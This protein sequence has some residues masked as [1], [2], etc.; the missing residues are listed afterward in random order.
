MAIFGL[1]GKEKSGKMTLAITRIVEIRED[2]RNKKHSRPIQVAN[3]FRDLCLD[4]HVDPFN[5]AYDG[6]GG[7]VVFGALLSELWSPKLLSVQFGGAPSDLRSSMADQRTGKQSY[8]NRVT[9]LWFQGLEFVQSEQIRGLPG[10]VAKELQARRYET[11]KQGEFLKTKVETKAEMKVRTGGKS[12]DCFVAGTLIST[13]SGD[14]PIESLFVGQEVLTP[15]G[16]SKIFAIHESETDS[17]TRVG[18]SNGKHLSGKGAHK[19]FT[20]D[21]GWRRMDTL[22]LTNEIESVKNLPIWKFLNALSTKVKTTGFKALADI[23]LADRK[24]HRRR[25]FYTDLSGLSTTALFLK[26][27]SFIIKTLIG[28]TTTLP[29]LNLWKAASIL[30]CTCVNALRTRLS[31]SG[32]VNFWTRLLPL[33]CIGTNHQ[34]V[35]RGISEMERCLG[36][37]VNELN[38][39]AGA[40]KYSRLS[41]QQ[42]IALSVVSTN[43]KE[44]NTGK[45]EGALF[46]AIHLMFSNITQRRIALSSVEQLRLPAERP[47]KVFNL[48]LEEHNAYYANGVLV[49]NCADAFAILIEL[50]RRR[51]GFVPG[52][53]GGARAK[54]SDG[55]KQKVQR[56]SRIFDPQGHY[57]PEELVEV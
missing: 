44:Q 53:Q 38:A 54:V 33:P 36:Q 24:T 52:G 11:T 46:A 20:W 48:T 14:V 43:L 42:S 27:C 21:E 47:V 25:D 4:A 41:G 15:F 50:C 31:N 29:I 30:G 45:P 55:W 40:V 2:M 57:Q 49:Q 10:S 28:K 22:S 16:S 26:A 51:F 18:L 5:A 6:S 19:I 12:P 1:Y 39:N 37:S 8:A 17:L 7:G 35:G 56:T 34:R 32:I 3:Q 23:I 13:P 9:E